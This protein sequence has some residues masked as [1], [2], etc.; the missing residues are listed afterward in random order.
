MMAEKKKTP[1]TP[2]EAVEKAPEVVEEVKETAPV[3]EIKK[4]HTVTL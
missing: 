2:K 4:S 1:S 3:V